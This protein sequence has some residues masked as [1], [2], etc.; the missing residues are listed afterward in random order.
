MSWIIVNKETGK[1]V[2]ETF[3]RTTMQAVN[4]NK[5]Q[6][7]TVMEWLQSVNKAVQS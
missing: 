5:Y 3:E 6:V 4:R 2:F 1:A 7:M